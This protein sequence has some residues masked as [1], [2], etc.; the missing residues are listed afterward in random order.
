M[1]APRRSRNDETCFDRK[2]SAYL[3]DVLQTY[4]THGGVEKD[5][6]ALHDGIMRKLERTL[7][8][9]TNITNR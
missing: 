6:R 2:Q 9:D 3:H 4:V 1:S 8:P 5:E 7:F